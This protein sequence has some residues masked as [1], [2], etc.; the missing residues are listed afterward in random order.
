M[1][2]K[3]SQVQ[4]TTENAVSI[5]R[6]KWTGHTKNIHELYRSKQILLKWKSCLLFDNIAV[7][8][9]DIDIGGKHRKVAI[10]F[11][12]VTYGIYIHHQARSSSMIHQI[13]KKGRVNL[14]PVKQKGR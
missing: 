2:S 8:N 7:S 12:R 9:E 5:E 4:S 10:V 11:A 1:Y 3:I 13:S 6:K 14:Q